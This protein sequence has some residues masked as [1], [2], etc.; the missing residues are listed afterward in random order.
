M[1]MKNSD[2]VEMIALNVGKGDAT[3]IRTGGYTC[4]IDTG[5]YS[6]RKKLMNALGYFGIGSFDAVFITH[7]HNDHSGGLRKLRKKDIPIGTIYASKYH[8]ARKTSEHPAVI[9]AEKMGK[10]VQWLTAGDIVP[11]GNSGCIFRVLAP[12]REIEENENDNSLVMM[13][14]SQV[15]N[16]LLTGD[17]EMREESILRHSGADLSCRV[18]KV[19]DHGDGDACS[20]KLIRAT[21]AEAAI[22][23]TDTEAKPNTP[24]PKLLRKLEE[25]RCAC[26]V[27]QDST[28]GIYVS[29]DKKGMEV[30]RIMV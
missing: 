24:A 21:G 17:M 22:I 9:N 16:I 14:E 7:T 15:G 23:S 3:I 10:K 11:L 18:L 30:S 4:L 13:L 29:M 2:K 6:A 27:T 28:I 19:P 8:P 12:D 26:Y 5:R 1:K 20:E 25:A